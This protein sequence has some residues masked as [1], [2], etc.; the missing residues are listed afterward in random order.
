MKV[1][2]AAAGSGGHVFPALAVAEALGR[3]GV[4]K[5]DVLFFGGDRMESDVVPA[6]GYP[7][8]EV[9]IHGLRRSL[10]I[11]NL[12]LPFMIRR[13]K[14]RIER[15]IRTEGIGVMAVFGGYVSGPAGLAARAC[16]IPLI[17]HEANAVPGLANRMLARSADTIFV[18]FE[19]ALRRFPGAR[20]VGNPLRSDFDNFDRQNARPLARRHYALDADEMV[21]GVVG[22]SQGAETLN[23][24]ARRLAHTEARDFSILHIPG[25]LHVESI[26]AEAVGVDAWH[27]LEFEHQIERFYAACDLVLARAGSMTVS[28]LQAT[29]TPS[30]FVPLPAGGGYQRENAA[31]FVRTGGAVV[32]NQDDDQLIVDTV[33]TLLRDS[34]R[35]TTMSRS[36]EV[37]GKSN[38]ADLVAERMLEAADA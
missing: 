25:S 12:N 37:V 14:R 21:L 26:S 32:L 9:D 24:I 34:E 8:T 36:A 6:A 4:P 15:A 38:A 16:S 3:L 28:E 20:V 22:G 17:V 11:D 31:D 18:A 1:G 30:V 19:A 29:G 33:V 13:A 10:S 35:L 5:R 2:I 27:V 7:F 23:D